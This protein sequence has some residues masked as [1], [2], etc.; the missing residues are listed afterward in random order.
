[1]RVCK[2]DVFVADQMEQ[3]QPQV[4]Q[5]WDDMA[6]TYASGWANP[7]A[8]LCFDVWMC[9]DVLGALDDAPDDTSTSSLSALA[10]G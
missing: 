8:T 1:M 2:T 4:S 7:I 3:S 10:A 6:A 9:L 5:G